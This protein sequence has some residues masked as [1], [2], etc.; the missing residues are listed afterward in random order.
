MDGNASATISGNNIE[1]NPTY[2]VYL[3]SV[4]TLVFYHNN[5]YGNGLNFYSD[6]AY[7]LGGVTGPGNY[8]GHTDGTKPCF[9]TY[10]GTNTP[11][12]ANGPFSPQTTDLNGCFYQQNGWLNPV[13][14]MLGK[15]PITIN[16]GSTYTDAGATATDSIDG[17][18]TSKIVATNTVNTAIIGTYTV[19]YN[20]TDSSGLSATPVVRTVNVVSSGG[21]GG[22][23]SGT[24]FPVITMLGITPVIV[25][26]GSTYIDAGATATDSIDGNITSKIV[27]TNTVNTAIIG[28]Y[29]VTY[30]VT[31]SSGLS[32]VPVVRTVD[33][34]APPVAPTLSV[35]T[36]EVSSVT[37][38]GRIYGCKDSTALNYNYFSAGKLSLCKYVV[39]TVTAAPMLTKPL[40]YIFT[41]T[42]YYGTTDTQ[43]KY[44]QIILN[45]DKNTE[46]LTTGTGSKGKEI[47]H[48]GIITLKALIKFQ[49]KYHLNPDG[50]VGPL[51][52]VVLM[53]VEKTF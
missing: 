17:N 4:P 37:G 30:N 24:Y 6:K 48:F 38:G 19:T 11:Y 9:Y 52:R 31:D 50:I 25:Q 51:T 41:K 10:G 43:V 27:T 1:N 16:Q 13:I 36:L 7:Q 22:G 32:A 29:T 26:E 20:V 34:I 3:I 47:T 23:G 53:K 35:P 40:T 5:I 21:G 49:I 12:D 15:T 44:L 46:L 14:T 45:Q 42:M 39:S 8:W 28:T 18:I 33:V 2:G